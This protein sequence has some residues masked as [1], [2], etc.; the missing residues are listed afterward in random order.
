MSYNKKRKKKQAKPDKL[1]G[2]YYPG[3]KN[4]TLGKKG[5]SV[6][7]CSFTNVIFICVIAICIVY[8]LHT[9]LK[10]TQQRVDVFQYIGWVQKL[11]LTQTRDPSIS[12]YLWFHRRNRGF[13]I[14]PVHSPQDYY[15]LSLPKKFKVHT[16]SQLVIESIPHVV[17]ITKPQFSNYKPPP[18]LK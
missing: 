17:F 13:Y 12:F 1:F 4:N 6:W 8:Y 9:Y 7:C 18:L 2:R 14:S 11:S 15:P 5:K 3:A 10:T 16:G